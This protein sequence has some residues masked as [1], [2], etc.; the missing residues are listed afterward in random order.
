MLENYETL[1]GIYNHDL[2]EKDRPFALVEMH[3][4]EDTYTSSLLY[5]RMREFAYHKVDSTFQISFLDFLALPVH[6]AT[7][8]ML[9]AAKEK[10]RE[11]RGAEEM[12][13]KLGTVK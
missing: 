4:A 8:M 5:E 3:T 2:E 10:A 13:K 1:F 12:F 11:D 6:M 9:V 7:E